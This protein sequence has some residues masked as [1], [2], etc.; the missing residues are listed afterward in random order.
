[1]VFVYIVSIIPIL[2]WF[3]AHW[4][5][6]P[7][8]DIY[9]FFLSLG[10]ITGILGITLFSINLVLSARL[11][12]LENSFNGLNQIYKKHH[13]IGGVCFILMMVHPLL[14]FISRLT[15]SF[16][17]AKILAIPGSDFFVDLGI[18]ALLT[19][20]IVLILTFF[21]KLPYE[22]W[23]LIHKFSGFSFI[24]AIFHSFLIPSTISENK[25]LFIYM[26]I[27]V[28][29][30]LI[31]YIYRTLLFKF[32]V[33]KYKY[34]VSKVVKLNKNTIAIVLTPKNIPIKYHAGQFIFVSFKNSVVP[35][36]FH[37]FSIAN[38]N[39]NS[40]V[41]VSKDEGDFTKKLLDIKVNT[42]AEVEG[43]FGRFS[44]YYY[45]NPNQIWVGGGIGI[46]PFIGMALGNTNNNVDLYYCIKDESE[47]L[48]FDTKKIN[49][50]LFYS[51]TMGHID[52][53]YIMNNSKSF[54]TS[55]FFICGPI[56]L[57]KSLRE[58]LNKLGIKNSRIHT[59]EF[60]FD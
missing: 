54:E 34:S 39:S 53:K 13:L 49:L 5:S 52:A 56:P 8:S 33:K 19:I 59:E 12:F 26:A 55:D 32:L 28:T 22:I 18:I 10:Q 58:G 20:M 7:F 23:K 30:G 37:P 17:Y 2:L 1:M 50:K 14:L 9:V 24:V 38:T 57:M 48:N 31:S 60:S 21:A 3:V 46:T 27:V 40:I 45:P 42:E 44:N 41:I 4:P 6:S 25:P 43:A 36:E 35:T 29:L 16:N 15:I 51:K 11:K 47:K